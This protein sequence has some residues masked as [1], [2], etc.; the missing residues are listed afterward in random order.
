MKR[1]RVLAS[2]FDDREG[3]MGNN[4]YDG[5]YWYAELSKNPFSKPFDFSALGKL[6]YK[7]KL[8]VTY[9]NKTL[10]AM[11][12]DVGAGGPSYPKIDLHYKLAKDLDFIS[13][14]LDYVYIQSP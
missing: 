5:H 3:Y 8:K 2:Y 1:Q 6:P 7:Y 10:T 9:K 14:G 12:G 13:A 11:K 4:L